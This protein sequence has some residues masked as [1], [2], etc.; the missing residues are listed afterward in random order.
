[1]QPLTPP[2]LEAGL[3]HIRSSPADS[4]TVELIVCRPDIDRREIL[5]E[6]KLDLEVGLV[7]DNWRARGSRM[8][9]D[10]AA[11][12]ARQVTLMNARCANLVAQQRQRWPLAGDQFYVDFDL[13]VE[14]LPAGSRVRLGSAVIEVSVEPHTGCAKF[15]SRFGLDALRFVN[16]P[17]GKRLRLRGLNAS[18]VEPGSVFPGDPIAR[19]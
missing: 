11:E 6:A 13:G 3:D 4:G 1:M 5:D 14:N 7:G 8:T 19:L 12:F 2:Q 16:S 9:A 10:G 15:S 17:E 18:V